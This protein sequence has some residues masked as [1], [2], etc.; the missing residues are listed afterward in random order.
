MGYGFLSSLPYAMAIG[1]CPWN[2]AKTCHGSS[3]GCPR[4]ATESPLPGTSSEPFRWPAAEQPHEQAELGAAKPTS[5]RPRHA[6]SCGFGKHSVATDLMKRPALYDLLCPLLG[7][8][9]GQ[10]YFPHFIAENTGSHR[11]R[12][13]LL[14]SQWLLWCLFSAMP[15]SCSLS[16]ILSK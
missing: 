13:S 7:R 5:T 3:Q 1:T 15:A 10:G 12:E 14:F 16:E 2:R 6:S 11:L 4:S 9:V 8:N